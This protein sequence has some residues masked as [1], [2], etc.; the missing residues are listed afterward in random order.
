MKSL[1][2][3]IT[4]RAIFPELI[5]ERGRKIEIILGADLL[6]Q[7]EF[8]I[9]EISEFELRD[10]GEGRITWNT[11]KEREKEIL[12]SPE[13]E[14]FLK[15]ASDRLDKEGKVTRYNISLLQKIDK[16]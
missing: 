14:E 16:L 10:H 2:L 3:T 9:E 15:S 11:S 4:E 12:V 8:S 13:Q 1:F 7:T 5:P 6:K